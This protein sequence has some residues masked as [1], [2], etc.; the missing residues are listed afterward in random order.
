MAWQRFVD[1]YAPLI[2]YWGRHRGLGATD[3]ADLVQDVLGELVV[4]LQTFEYD[5]NQRFRG[6]LRTIVVNRAANMQRRNKL[7]PQS[8]LPAS[9]SLAVA[10]DEEDLFA[11]TQYRC[12]VA[13]R[14]LL[15][16]Q[17][18]FG[19][20]TWQAGWLQIVEGRKA[21]DVAKE[22][23]LSVNAVYLAKSRLLARLRR[24]LQGLVDLE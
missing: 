20:A 12:H 24:E 16:L 23:K 9:V 8:G 7:A 10:E 18:D 14:T 11:E 1:L 21:A 6:W 15:L 19:K 2:F 5:A 4:K 13:K 3:A 22:L 17:A